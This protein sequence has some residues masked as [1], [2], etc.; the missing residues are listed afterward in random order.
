MPFLNW[1]LLIS[2]VILILIFE[3]SSNLAN[4]LM[5]LA[6]T[7]THVMRH[8]FAMY[9]YTMHGNGAFAKVML[10]VIPFCFLESVLVAAASLKCSQIGLGTVIDQCSRRY[11]LDDVETWAETCIYPYE[12]MNAL[13][14][15][16]F[17]KVLAE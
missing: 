15:E 9:S 6:V 16:L 17:I 12:T 4:G 3:T 10:L 8:D 5:V 2:I 14:I 1:L 13:P 7:L 11:D